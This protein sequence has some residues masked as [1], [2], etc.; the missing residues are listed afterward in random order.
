MTTVYLVRHGQASFGAADYDQLSP[1]GERQSDLL[2]RW[3]KQTGRNIE[4]VAMGAMKRHRQTAEACLNALGAEGS[5]RSID[6]GFNEYDHEGILR[7][8]RPDL[9]D[10]VAVGRYLVEQAEQGVDPKRASQRVFME[11]IARWTSGEHDA[12]YPESWIAFKQRCIDA[13]HQAA[14]QARERGHTSVVVFTSGGPIAAITQAAMGVPDTNA[15]DLA[16]ALMNAGVTQLNVRPT[17]RANNLRLAHFNNVAHLDVA[18]DPALL[19]FR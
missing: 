16:W 8:H 3:W 15:F 6:P 1:L 4:S 9:G 10:H 2:G 5:D 17:T 13:T 11:A 14:S 12:D 18:C 19:T 7:I